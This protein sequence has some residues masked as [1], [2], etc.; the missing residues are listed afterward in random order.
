MCIHSNYGALPDTA[1]SFTYMYQYD[2][3]ENRHATKLYHILD[4]AIPAV[5]SEP[6]LNRRQFTKMY[7]DTRFNWA[8]QADRWNAL[9]QSI[10]AKNPDRKT[11]RKGIQL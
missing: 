4:Q 10:A 2:E 8:N 3:D 9:L 5:R 6:V 1:S 11:A 7:A